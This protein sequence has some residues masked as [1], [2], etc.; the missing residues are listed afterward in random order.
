MGLF[1]ED[2][3]SELLFGLAQIN[4]GTLCKSCSIL[5]W[6]T[7]SSSLPLDLVY[8]QTIVTM[9]LITV[10]V[11]SYDCGFIWQVMAVKPLKVSLATVG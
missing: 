5:I 8:H 4:K 11:K 1:S 9:V 6:F 7:I 2:W 3:H 10:P